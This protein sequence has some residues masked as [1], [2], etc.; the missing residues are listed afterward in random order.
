[1]DKGMIAA[2]LKDSL[3]DKL[4][5]CG[6]GCCCTG[7]EHDR[8]RKQLLH[9]ADDKGVFTLTASERKELD[10]IERVWG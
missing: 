1:M 9:L 4:Q 3:W 7:E 2:L 10:R 6:C 5:C 8:A